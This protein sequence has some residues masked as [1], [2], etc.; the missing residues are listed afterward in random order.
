MFFQQELSTHKKNAIA[1]E[2]KLPA[3][4]ISREARWR[5]KQVALVDRNAPKSLEYYRRNDWH[6]MTEK[7]AT[8][9]KLDWNPA[10]EIYSF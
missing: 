8:E 1:T 9:S 6:N 5:V 7:G 3:G 4:I 2:M 10:S